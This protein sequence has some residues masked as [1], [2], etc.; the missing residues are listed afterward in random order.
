MFDF[1]FFYF[2]SGGWSIG[3]TVA[4]WADHSVGG[5][6]NDRDHTANEHHV[7]QAGNCD[8]ENVRDFADGAENGGKPRGGVE[9]LGQ[10]N[11]A[12]QLIR[13]GPFI[14]QSISYGFIPSRDGDR[15][16]D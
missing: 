9:D 14:F 16:D 13:D 15:G 7:D 8:G 12:K 2:D 11:G 10:V 5:G 1:V 6:I 4:G 3:W